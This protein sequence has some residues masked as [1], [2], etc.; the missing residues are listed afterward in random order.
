VL[1]RGTV[2]PLQR[3]TSAGKSG[4]SMN[5]INTKE[6]VPLAHKRLIN[7]SYYPNG[8]YSSDLDA[9]CSWWLS[10][11]ATVRMSCEGC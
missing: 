3:S 10:T 1:L 11:P 4:T 2:R 6:C 8:T 9:W 7:V 5:C